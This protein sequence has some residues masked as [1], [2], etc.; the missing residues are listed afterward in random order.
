MKTI[1]MQQIRE[2]LDCKNIAVAGASGKAGS[3]G[4][5]VLKHL[6]M[7]NYNV[8]PVN[9]NYKGED[10]GWTDNVKN[11]PDIP[12]NLIILTNKSRSAGIVSDAVAKGIK[13]IWIQ[14][15]SDSPEALKLVAENNLNCIHGKCI[16][17]FTNPKGVHKFHYRLVKFFGQLPK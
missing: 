7:L 3:F 12:M 9:P 15:M 2:F 14:Q 10:T 1:S 16:F 5:D 4:A 17:M 11:L 8:F 13:N 6:R